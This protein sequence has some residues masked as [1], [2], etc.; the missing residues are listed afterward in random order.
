MI[1]H[2]YGDDDL[3]RQRPRSNEVNSTLAT[4]GNGDLEQGKQLVVALAARLTHARKKHPEFALDAARAWNVIRSET[5][6]LCR[7]V[8][9]E[10]AERVQDELLDVL[11]TSVR[12][13]NGEYES[14][15]ST[16]EA[17]S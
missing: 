17:R 10:S 5:D 11:A 15:A 16:E 8:C 3:Y 4:L 7:A 14:A 13:Y 6:E 2:D 9:C 1:S 12:M